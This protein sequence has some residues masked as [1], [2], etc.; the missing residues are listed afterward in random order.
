MIPI[1]A[2]T[3]PGYRRGGG[4]KRREENK[5][6][7][8]SSDDDVLERAY[9]YEVNKCNEMLR[10]RCAP[11][12]ECND[13]RGV[14]VRLW[15]NTVNTYFPSRH[16]PRGCAANTPNSRRATMTVNTRQLQTHRH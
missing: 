14:E 13:A 7:A 3:G 6:A 9:R 4:M 12:T 2:P 15:P 1:G 10:E 16:A 11:T 8:D 5:E